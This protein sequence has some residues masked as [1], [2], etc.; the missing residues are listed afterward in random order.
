[1]L[2]PLARGA[3]CTGVT[4]HVVYPVEDD[5]TAMEIQIYMTESRV[6]PRYPDDPSFNGKPV[7][8][9]CACR[10]CCCSCWAPSQAGRLVI[11]MPKPDGN[12]KRPVTVEMELG[13]TEI[14]VRV[15]DHTSDERR[16]LRLDFL[17]PPQVLPGSTVA[18][19]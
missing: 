7:S 15:H 1:M 14:I 17:V 8:V 18:A 3:H 16:S 9:S 5:Q 6:C 11:P 2:P 4:Q 12:T 13:G 19:T 10:C